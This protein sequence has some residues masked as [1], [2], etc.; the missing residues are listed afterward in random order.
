MK[1]IARSLRNALPIQGWLLLAALCVLSVLLASITNA[2]YGPDSRIYLAWTYWYLGHPQADAAQLA[3]NYLADDP[4]LADCWSCWPD[5]YH[6]SFFTGPYAAVV[7]P[8]ILL[9]LLSAP[10][11]ALFGP[12]GLMVVPIIG[13]ALAIVATVLLAS[14]LWGP[15]WALVA[16][17]MLLLPVSVSRW[18]VVAHTEGPAFAL[19][20]LPLLLLPLAKRVTRTHVVWYVVL[21][22]VGM[23]NRQFAIALPVA[24]A[25]AW[26]LVAVRD[27]AFRNAWLPFAVWGNVVGFG[28]LAAQMVITPRIFGGEELALSQRFDDL[29]VKYF[30]VRGVAALPDVTWNIIHSDLMRVR[31]DLAL[32]ALLIAATVAVVWRFR[33]ELSALAAGAFA[34][35][36]AINIVEF[37]P[38]AFRYHAPIV[39]LLVLAVV[40][41]LV[42]LWGPIRRRPSRS[43]E[44]GLREPVPLSQR[45]RRWEPMRWVGKLPVHAWATIVGLALAGIAVS[46]NRT[47][48]FS[49]TSMYHLAWTYRLL[50]HSPADATALTYQ[51]LSDKA[52]FRDDC[53]GWSCWQ[54]GNTWLFEHAGSADPNLIYPLLSAPFVAVLGAPGLLVVPLVSFVAVIGMLTYFAASRWGALA[55]A[56]TG[57]VFVISD[58]I[59]V[60]SL[61]GSAD[62]LA[63][64]LCC[65]CLFTLPLDGRRGRR[66]LVTFAVLVGLLLGARA[67]GMA[68]VGAVAVAWAVAAWRDRSVRNPW[69]PYAAVSTGLAVLMI[70]LGQLTPIADARYLGRASELTDGGN[71]L[72][73]L[74][75]RIAHTAK[76][77]AQYLAVDAVVCAVLVLAAAVAPFRARKDPLAAM[78]LGGVVVA[79]LLEI[80]TGVPSGVRQFSPVFP[81][82][83]LT[84][85]GVLAGLFERLGPWEVPGVRAPAALPP[86]PPPLVLTIPSEPAANGANAHNSR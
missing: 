85:M 41:L 73:A 72:A 31:Y 51:E 39:P 59:A 11:V 35:V 2:H 63:I 7:G 36:S 6:S 34:V 33:S 53:T 24:V 58:R 46:V 57:V 5:D 66:E 28:V 67:P 61:T 50:G 56:V 4:G 49:P 9:P 16:G 69:L 19:L 15:R 38:A 30:G 84:A 13:Y 78:A 62:M 26:L 40:A 54:D 8:R 27:R 21:V 71:V 75:E 79:A 18:S 81:I 82:L 1:R 52:F 43:T 17:A 65:A 80:M 37:W 12:A 83:L 23:L 32:V 29:A 64:A 22:A 77:D 76:L 44:A 47:W 60:A 68:L 25:A 10:F 42:D 14:R 3:Y 48:Q 55:G 86:A 70:G 74:A 20:V 45:A